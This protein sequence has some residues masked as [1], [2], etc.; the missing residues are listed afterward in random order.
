[1]TTNER[2]LDM[3]SKALEMEKK[4]KAFYDQAV[5]MCKNALGIE[6]FKILSNDELVH[7]ERIK[8]IYTALSGGGKW[9][10]AWAAMKF[11]HKDLSVLFKELAAKRGKDIKADTGDIEALGIGV[12][13]E[14]KSV[15]F[16]QEH[17]KSAADPMERKFLDQM[18]VEEKGH[19]AVLVDTK[20]Y[21]ENPAAWFSEKERSGYDGG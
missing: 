13:F 9:T 6:I 16:Y 17:L 1:M 12:D 7:T 21:L 4:G 11:A 2:A 15:K 14:Q 18:I 5:H 8:T 20:Q 19:F 10:D 3:L